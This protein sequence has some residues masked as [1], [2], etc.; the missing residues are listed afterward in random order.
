MRTIYS[1]FIL[2]YTSTLNIYEFCDYRLILCKIKTKFI[3]L[4][5]HFKQINS[6]C[7]MSN[8]ICIQKRI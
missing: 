2:I 8:N 4:R 5:E 7:L 3:C 1:V 6:G